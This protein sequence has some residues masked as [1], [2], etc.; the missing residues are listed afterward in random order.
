MKTSAKQSSL[1]RRRKRPVMQIG[2]ATPQRIARLRRLLLAWGQTNRRDFYWR[3]PGVT[4]FGILVTE[5]LVARTRAESVDPVIRRLMR[6]FPSPERLATAQH[7]AVASILRPLG[8]HRTRARL[9]V[10]CARMLVSDHSGVVPSSVDRL[11]RLPYV[12]RYAANAV[13][14]VA[15]E[16]PRAVLDANVARIYRRVFSVP[17]TDERLT[18]AEGLWE[19]ADRVLSKSRPRDFNWAML[20]LGGTVCT[21]R[22]PV[23]EGCPLAVIC[24]AKREC[25]SVASSLAAG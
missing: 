9:L 15:F 13:A 22:S 25:A 16:Q 24:D 4:P 14:S 3:E 8:L 10:R 18:V 5:I 7:T 11:I 1:R 17:A 21:P 20:D 6:R 12:G 2:T 19:L 23:C